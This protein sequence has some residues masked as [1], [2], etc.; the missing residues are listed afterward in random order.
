MSI[1]LSGQR[2]S[3]LWPPTANIYYDDIIAWDEYDVYD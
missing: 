1:P 2:K 3:R